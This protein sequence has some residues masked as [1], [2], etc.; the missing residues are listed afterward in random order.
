M[1]R[2]EH[3]VFPRLQHS[4][5]KTVLTFAL[6]VQVLI[7]SFNSENVPMFYFYI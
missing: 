2:I 1:L 3:T 6:I 5:P 7:V 4:R